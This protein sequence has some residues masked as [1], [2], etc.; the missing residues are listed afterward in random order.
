M[1]KNLSD[2]FMDTL[3]DYRGTVNDRRMNFLEENFVPRDGTI[4]DMEF[5]VLRLLGYTGSL[6]D[7][8]AEYLG[9]LGGSIEDKADLLSDSFYADYFGQYTVYVDGT[10]YRP[11]MVLDPDE[12]DRYLFDC[13]YEYWS[14]DKVPAM[15]MDPQNDYY[16]IEAFV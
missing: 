14:D 13:T 1:A 7:M 16:A 4:D 3:Y 5:Q 2:A 12:S 10:D 11:V 6:T 9:N 15:V 8:W